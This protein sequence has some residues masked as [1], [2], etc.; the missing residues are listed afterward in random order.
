MALNRLLRQG[1][2]IV[3]VKMFALEVYLSLQV[4][5]NPVIS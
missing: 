3:R 2:T 5:V 4:Y 1:I